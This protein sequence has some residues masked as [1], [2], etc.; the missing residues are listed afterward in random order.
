MAHSQNIHWKRLLAEGAAIIVSILLAFWIDAWW[1]DQRDRIGETA[2]L[3]S[4]L[5][6]L[7]DFERLFSDNDIYVSAIRESAHILLEAAAGPDNNLSDDKLDRL[8]SDVTWAVDP[9]NMD[10]PI[11]GSLISNGGLAIISNADLRRQ[12]GRWSIKLSSVRS[13]IREDLG[14]YNRTLMPFFFEHISMTQLSNLN[15]H[16]PGFPDVFYSYD[17]VPMKAKISH[18]KVLENLKFRNIMLGRITTTT[19]IVE[20][21]DSEIESQLRTIIGLIEN[22]LRK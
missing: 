9:A 13:S 10:T 18:R 19:N 5:G 12:L 6:E 16:R 11:L 4:L 3:T 21:R 1:S 15:V 22:E 14:F 17:S 7:Q 20:W 2:A 8:L